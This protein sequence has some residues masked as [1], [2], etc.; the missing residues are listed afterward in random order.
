MPDE[1]L[2]NSMEPEKEVKDTA[3]SG[4]GTFVLAFI[5]SACCIGIIKL[6][7]YVFDVYDNTVYIAVPVLALLFVYLIKKFRKGE[8]EEEEED[9]KLVS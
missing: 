9:E 5:L 7:L 2:N 3:W 1:N 6:L 8:E 4:C